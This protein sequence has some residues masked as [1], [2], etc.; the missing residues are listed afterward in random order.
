MSDPGDL[1]AELDAALEVAASEARSFL[2]ALDEDPVQPSDGDGVAAALGGGL[3]EGGE[4]AP[5]AVRELARVGRAGATR[6]AGPRFFHFVIGGAT[7]AALAADWLTS[8]FD[9]N[10][11]AWVGSPFASRLETICLEWLRDLFEL[12]PQFGGVLVTGGTMANFVCLAVAR[13]WCVERL[14][15]RARQVGLAGLRQIPVFSSGYIHASATKS[16]GLLGIGTD[17][18]RK[19][20]RDPA[21]RLDLDV[22]ERELAELGGAPA[23]VVASAGEVNAGDFDPIEAMAD[24]ASEHDAWLHVDGA[25]G[26]FA[27]VSPKAAHLAAGTE[28]ARSVSSD[29]HKWLNVPHDCGF[30]FVREPERLAATFGEQA[31]YLPSSAES[32][33]N[34]GFMGPEGSRRARAL[35]IWATLRAYGRSGYRAM[36]ERHLALAQRL[37]ARVDEEPDLERLAAVPLNIVCFR[38]RPTDAGDHELDELNRRLGAALLRDGRVFAGTTVFESKVAFRPAIVNWRSRPEDVD[39]LID[40]LLEL[41]G[42]LRDQLPAMPGGSPDRG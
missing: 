6:S 24:L 9:Q 33:P 8:S 31:P 42:G 3:P 1:R 2:A 12:P 18:V 13:D 30:A 7:P 5:V 26:L 19:L 27:R 29:G 39:A 34:W 38:W 21:G 11:G 25:F 35:T 15:A 4:G 14:G 10:A 22:L 41:A 28:R 17:N 16:L 36:V 37:A 23:I 40:V 20:T 32:R